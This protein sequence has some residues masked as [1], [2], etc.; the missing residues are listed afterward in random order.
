MQQ[1]IE[2]MMDERQDDMLLVADMVAACYPGSNRAEK[3]HR[4]SVARAAWSACRRKGWTYRHIQT[5]GGMNVYYNPGSVRSYVLAKFLRAD[6]NN[7]HIADGELRAIVDGRSPPRHWH[8]TYLDGMQPGGAFWLHV[9]IWK[10][11][12][13]GRTED[14]AMHREALDGRIREEFGQ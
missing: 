9:E 13:D 11:D 8:Q 5:P 12:L 6:F 3:K 2:K 10:A 14:A 1:V 4:V 7:Q